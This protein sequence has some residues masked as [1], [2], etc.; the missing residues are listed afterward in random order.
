[1][2]ADFKL[3]IKKIVSI[4]LPR[5]VNYEFIIKDW[6]PL[7]DLEASSQ[8]LETKRFFNNLQP[9]I[10]RPPNNKKILVLSPHID[11]EIFGCGGVLLESSDTCEILVVYVANKMKDKVQAELIKNEAISV[12][13]KLNIHAPIFLNYRPGRIS[14]AAENEIREAIVEFSPDII[15]TTFILDDHDDH[16]RVNLLLSNALTEGI[17]NNIE[18]WQFQI[19]STV[20]PNVVVDITRVMSEKIELMEQY[21]NVSGNRNWSHYIQGANAMNCRFIPGKTKIYAESFFVLPDSEYLALSKQ[22]FAHKNEK[23]YKGEFYKNNNT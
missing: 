23:L 1:M 21:E 6:R 14:L 18:I 4:V 3:L 5:R 9:S 2:L 17:N 10:L 20:I 22:Y 7:F 16:R 13:N 8:L 12:C 11:D 15:S 19:Y